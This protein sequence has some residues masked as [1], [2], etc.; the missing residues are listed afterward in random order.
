MQQRWKPAVTVAAIAEKDGRYLLVEEEQ[1]E[2]LMLN[3][4]AGH[5]EPHES[6]EQAVVLEALEESAYPFFPTALVG[7]YLS[8]SL[9]PAADGLGGQVAATYLR[10]AYAGSVGERIAGR[11]LDTGIVCAVWMTPE[12]IRATR[13]RH[14]SPMVLRCIEDH[15][16]GRRLPLDSVYTDPDHLHGA[17]TP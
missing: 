16:A 3:N 15:L 11:R 6:P 5:L 1:P 14:R 17:G 10:F 4:P 2:G 12:E 7:V 9:K 13:H 8:T